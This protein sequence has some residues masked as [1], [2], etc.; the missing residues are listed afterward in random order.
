[1]VR[2]RCRVDLRGHK[3]G[4]RPRPKEIS[5]KKR[6]LGIL[7]CLLAFTVYANA[8]K[9]QGGAVIP[10][11]NIHKITLV[12]YSGL[13]GID[14]EFYIYN[15][16]GWVSAGKI[17]ECPFAKE[18]KLSTKE[19]LGKASYIAYK[20]SLPDSKKWFINSI[21]HELAF[22]VLEAS[23]TAFKS[24]NSFSDIKDDPANGFY[25]F[26]TTVQRKRYEKDV[27]VKNAP[28][29]II[30]FQPPKSTLWEI[31]G[32]V[33]DGKLKVTTSYH[34]DIDR[35]KPYWIISVCEEHKAYTIAA[36]AKHNNL[37]FE[38]SGLHGTMLPEPGD[39]AEPSGA[40]PA[41]PADDTEAQ[42]LKLKQL[43]DGGLIDESEY[44]KKKAKV[45]GL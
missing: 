35:C 34:K 18:V 16:T 40:E 32:V 20:C 27:R 29:C 2:W 30:L 41:A 5:M 28:K 45:L 6:I 37:C 33:H 15:E 1:M 23:N 38:F 8:P 43:Y 36:Y 12:N 39:G 42:L 3:T 26:D 21:G 4:R 22:Y 19:N 25:K 13:S 7:L 17:A 24:M 31:Y 10:A 14:V 44:R 11:G 9:F